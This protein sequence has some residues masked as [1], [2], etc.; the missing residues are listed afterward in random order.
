MTY[1]N[2]T[3]IE[4]LWMNTADDRPVGIV[5]GYDIIEERWKFYIGTGFGHSLE[6]DI[7]RIIDMGQKF[8]SL[9][10]IRCFGEELPHV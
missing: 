10:F 6:G 8:Y 9:E 7:L 4:V 5:R 1:N 2:L 3:H